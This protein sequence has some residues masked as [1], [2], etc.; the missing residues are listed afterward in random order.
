MHS[1]HRWRC[2]S[3]VVCMWLFI[4][5]RGSYT[6]SYPRT[7]AERARGGDCCV[8]R[9]CWQG[10]ARWVVVGSFE[11]VNAVLVRFLPLQ[12]SVG[13]AVSMPTN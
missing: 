10:R 11:S 8:V 6:R 7:P 13:S 3:L 2:L 12:K 9:P 1:L 4:E 5:L